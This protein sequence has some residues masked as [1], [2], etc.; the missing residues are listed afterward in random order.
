M[1]TKIF[2]ITSLIFISL[3]FSCEALG[4]QEPEEYELLDG[5]VENLNQ[6]EAIRFIEGDKAFNDQIFT[7]ETGLGPIFTGTSCVSCHAGDGKGHPF[8]S[9]TRF[10]QDLPGINN[11]LEMGAPQLQNRAIPGYEPETLPSG[12]PHAEFLAPIVTGLGFLDAVS[13]EDLLSMADPDDLDGDGISGRVHWND[14]PDYVKDRPGTISENGK[15]ITRFGKKANMYDLLHQTAD[16]YNQDIGINSYYEPF[17]TY[18]GDKVQPE[19]DRKT[20]NDVVFYLKTLKAPIPRNQ[21][22]PEVVAGKALFENTQCTACHKPTLRTSYSPITAI[23]YQEFHPYTDMLLHDMGPELDDGYTE[24]YA[25]SSEWRTAPLW[26]IGL[27]KDSQGGE[28]YLMHDGRA[29]SIE[30]AILLHGGEAQ[31]AKNKYQNLS[32]QE[33]SQLIKFI[34]SL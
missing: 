5:P 20:I 8:V 26:G 24:G 12:A 10:G 25:L 22:N 13:D 18:S 3:L 32:Q 9:F 6:A 21:D 28:Y 4:P 27:S 33:K 7:K 34:E 23:S 31:N 29:R 19:I 15:Y 16:A 30:E 17:D 1:K 14:R 11:F 2:L